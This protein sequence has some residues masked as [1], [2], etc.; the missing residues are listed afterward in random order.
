MALLATP[1]PIRSRQRSRGKRTRARLSASSSVNPGRSPS[2]QLADAVSPVPSNA[3]SSNVAFRGN[4][5]SILRNR[6]S[7][8]R[9]WA[10]ALRF[11]SSALIFSLASFSFLLL[12]LLSGYLFLSSGNPIDHGSEPS[13]AR[14]R[15]ECSAVPRA[16]VSSSLSLSG[17][18]RPSRASLI[19]S[20]RAWMGRGFSWCLWL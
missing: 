12:W 20:L 4:R 19:A 18:N 11:S 7:I 15:P 3:G 13:V 10:A 9:R 1:S 17:M 6:S 14:T 5:A 16:R 8:D 2:T